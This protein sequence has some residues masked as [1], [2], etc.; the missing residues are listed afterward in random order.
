[1]GARVLGGAA[2]RGGV[3]AR[4]TAGVAGAVRVAGGVARVLASAPSAARVQAC[5]QMLRGEVDVAALTVA[6]GRL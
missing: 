6:L 3:G 2:G 1:M 5:A 4:A